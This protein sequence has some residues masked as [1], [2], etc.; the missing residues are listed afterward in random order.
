[1]AFSARTGYLVAYN[2]AQLATVSLIVYS[3]AEHNWRQFNKPG[4]SKSLLDYPAKGTLDVVQTYF[5]I[6]LLLASL[7]IIH[8]LTGLSKGS[9]V[10]SLTQIGFKAVI[11]F[12]FI[13][14]EPHVH[15]YRTT[16]LLLLFWALGDLARYPF[17]ITTLLGVDL[18]FIKWLRYSAWVLLYPIGMTLETVVVY[19]N[20]V[21]LKRSGRLSYQLPNK[22]NISFDMPSVLYVYIGILAPIGA[23]GMLSYMHNQRRKVLGGQSRPKSQ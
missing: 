12:Q 8:S 21:F 7:E 13:V 6:N 16:G 20:I 2:L 5:K 10:A 14:A 3:I 4:A 11:Y 15:N 23:Y 19:Y 18:H 22:Y 9:P 1:M 17:Y